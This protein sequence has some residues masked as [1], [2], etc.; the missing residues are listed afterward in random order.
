MHW[1]HREENTKGAANQKETAKLAYYLKS[2]TVTLSLML[3]I[4]KVTSHPSSQCPHGAMGAQVTNLRKVTQ[5]LVDGRLEPETTNSDSWAPAVTPLGLL[6]LVDQWHE[7][8]GISVS[9]R[10]GKMPRILASREISP[11]LMSYLLWSWSE[12]GSDMERMLLGLQLEVWAPSGKHAPGHWH[13]G[14][15]WVK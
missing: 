4:I 2:N 11:G 7:P 12:S 3:V 9:G 10:F 6:L 15:P 13:P 1:I 5:W 14:L 8:R